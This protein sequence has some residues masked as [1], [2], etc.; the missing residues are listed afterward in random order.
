M[1]ILE[2]GVGVARGYR[3]SLGESLSPFAYFYFPS[4]TSD[5]GTDLDAEKSTTG[6]LGAKTPVLCTTI[7]AL[8]SNTFTLLPPTWRAHALV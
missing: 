7:F 2:Q 5:D 6:S 1:F 4:T 3:V 8:Y